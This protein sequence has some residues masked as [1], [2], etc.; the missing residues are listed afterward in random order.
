MHVHDG[1]FLA[2]VEN[3]VDVRLSPGSWFKRVIGRGPMAQTQEPASR[4]E[5]MMVLED[6]QLLLIRFAKCSS[7][8]HCYLRTSEDYL[9][10]NL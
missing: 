2:E 6:M 10:L 3:Q 8:F 9:L 5:I 4:E 7:N 1:T